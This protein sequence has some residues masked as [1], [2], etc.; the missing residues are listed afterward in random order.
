MKE[1]RIRI[2]A[3]ILE[4]ANQAHFENINE[5]IISLEK[6]LEANTDIKAMEQTIFGVME[7]LSI[8]QHQ[9]ENLKSEMEI[10]RDTQKELNKQTK[11]VVE[12][13]TKAINEA[14]IEE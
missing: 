9:I 6:R 8:L 14:F 1:N 7:H 2:K 12:A 11:E 13:L 5:Y 3:E 4:R 10:S